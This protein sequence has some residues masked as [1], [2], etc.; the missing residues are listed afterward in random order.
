MSDHNSQNALNGTVRGVRTDLQPVPS[1][2]SLGFLLSNVILD[3]L[4]RL[5][6]YRNIGNR[7]L[8]SAIY[9]A[10]RIIR[11]REAQEKDGEGN[12]IARTLDRRNEEDTASER[13]APVGLENRLTAREELAEHAAIYATAAHHCRELAEDARYDLP[14]DVQSRVAWTAENAR[15]TLLQAA[16]RFNDKASPAE[17]LAFVARVQQAKTDHQ[18][19]KQNAGEVAAIVEDAINGYEVPTNDVDI[20]DSLTGVDVHQYAIQA[21]IGIQ[22][23]LVRTEIN[24]ARFPAHTM[25][26]RRM[27]SDAAILE[28]SVPR[29]IA[30]VDKL[31][32]H[33]AGVLMAAVQ[34]GRNLLS[35]DSIKAAYGAGINR[36]VERASDSMKEAR[37]EV[38][39]E[40]TEAT[41]S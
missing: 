3:P 7:A 33:Y 41:G 8:S 38:E 12:F 27:A 19:W 1:A 18:F 9:A 34:G 32:D 28:G 21:G 11:E 2:L 25:L 13:E 39:R 30:F 16:P 37:A 5:A 35:S 14:Q 31:E 10:Q 6:C 15:K 40:I 17:Q 4:V 23:T 24:M 26:G 20:I 36:A 29:L 22:Q